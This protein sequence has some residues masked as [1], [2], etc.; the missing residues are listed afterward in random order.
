MIPRLIRKGR[1]VDIAVDAKRD[2]MPQVFGVGRND[3]RAD[4]LARAVAVEFDE[5]VSVAVDRRAAVVGDGGLADPSPET[6]AMKAKA[7]VDRAAPPL[8]MAR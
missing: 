6:H 5:P 2:E 1:D 7:L 3:R 8:F 4:Q